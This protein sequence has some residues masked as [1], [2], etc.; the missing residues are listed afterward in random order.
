M[1]LSISMLK[2]KLCSSGRVLPCTLLQLM[3]SAVVVPERAPIGEGQP[4]PHQ[5]LDEFK[6]ALYWSKFVLFLWEKHLCW[7]FWPLCQRKPGATMG[8]QEFGHQWQSKVNIFSFG[9]CPHPNHGSHIVQ[10]VRFC[11]SYLVI[12]IPVSFLFFF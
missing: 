11:F 1:L 6:F 8:V 7:T 2:L 3:G 10:T 5:K 4:P 12:L 9:V